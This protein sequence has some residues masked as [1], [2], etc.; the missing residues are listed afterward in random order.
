MEIA[1]G[2]IIH[3]AAIY[4]SFAR[5]LNAESKRG[6]YRGQQCDIPQDYVMGA[7]LVIAA[8]A[9]DFLDKAVHWDETDGVFAYDHL[10]WESSVPDCDSLPFYLM[11]HMSPESLFSASEGKV[12]D[13]VKILMKAWLD[14]H[15]AIPQN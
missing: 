15:D 8:S 9:A 5:I 11:R 2:N 12:D 4:G 10:D 6:V 1:A 13:A 7:L 3:T 14:D